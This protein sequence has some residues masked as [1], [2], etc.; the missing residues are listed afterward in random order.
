VVC[1]LSVDGAFEG[2]IL[3]RRCSLP[4]AMLLELILDV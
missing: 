1:A 3:S 4:G 2:L